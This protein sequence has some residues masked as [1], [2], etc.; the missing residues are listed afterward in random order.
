MDIIRKYITLINIHLLF[1]F[2]LFLLWI[3]AWNIAWII[4]LSIIISWLNRSDWAVLGTIIDV[5]KGIVA[6][7]LGYRSSVLICYIISV[8]ILHFNLISFVLLLKVLRVVFWCY[9]SDNWIYFKFL[10]L[11]F[12]VMWSALIVCPSFYEIWHNFEDSAKLFTISTCELLFKK[13]K[14]KYIFKFFFFWPMSFLLIRN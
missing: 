14:K 9:K 2:N 8:E 3:I 5:W 6:V 1:M 13:S 10:S 7:M 12:L 11:H 4:R